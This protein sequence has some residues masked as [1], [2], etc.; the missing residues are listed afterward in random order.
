MDRHVWTIPEVADTVGPGAN[1]RNYL[2]QRDVRR[3][4]EAARALKP[5]FEIACSSN[6]LAL[7]RSAQYVRIAF[8]SRRA[9]QAN[10]PLYRARWRSR[11]A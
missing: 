1:L 4:L 9:L 11:A 6:A 10:V 8:E 7:S 3:C 2:E 5:I